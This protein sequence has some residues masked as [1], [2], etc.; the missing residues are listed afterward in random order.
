[1]FLV[2]LVQHA[3]LCQPVICVVVFQSI[4]TIGTVTQTFTYRFRPRCHSD[5]PLR[6][7]ELLLAVE[8]NPSAIASVCFESCVQEKPSAFQ[9]TFLCKNSTD[10]RKP[11]PMR[12]QIFTLNT[13]RI[14]CSRSSALSSGNAK[15]EIVSPVHTKCFQHCAPVQT[16]HRRISLKAMFVESF[17]HVFRKHLTRVT[18]SVE[19]L[20][21]SPDLPLV[22]KVL[23]FNAWACS[24]L[25]N[26]R[27][28]AR[29]SKVELPQ[30]CQISIRLCSLSVAH[31]RHRIAELF[32]SSR[33]STHFDQIFLPGVD[34]NF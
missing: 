27:S 13:S 28:V 7:L 14:N 18:S 33:V 22:A 12:S 32:G 19:T 3:A 24:S 4:Q 30:T 21:Q 29:I 6:L 20:E 9:P 10:V 8:T 26:S 11:G 5:F 17:L 1:M 25:P 15:D 31:N 34:R 2:C 23:L 16:W